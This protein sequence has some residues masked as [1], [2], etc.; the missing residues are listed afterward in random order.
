[1][2]WM[3][4][5]FMKECMSICTLKK[6]FDVQFGINGEIQSLE[7]RGVQEIYCLFVKDS[8]ELNQWIMGVQN[9]NKIFKFLLRS[10]PNS[11]D[12]I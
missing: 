4:A 3:E 2:L 1:M 7:Y 9:P 11:P 5:V 12:I 8:L 6:D 10:L